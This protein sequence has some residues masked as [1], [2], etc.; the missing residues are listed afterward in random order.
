MPQNKIEQLA[1]QQ[2]Q[3]QLQENK[4]IKLLDVRGPDEYKIASIEGALLI[5]ETVAQEILDSWP[6]ETKMIFHCHHG[7]RSQQACEFFQAQGFQNLSNMT[8]G[9]DAWSVEVDSSVP[10]Y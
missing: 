4:E 9:I 2:V 10:R 3:T 8:G 7:F 6:K 1:P 5:S